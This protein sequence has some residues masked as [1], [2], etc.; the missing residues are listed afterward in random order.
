[1][2]NKV[3]KNRIR[4]F[5]KTVA[6]AIA[7]ALLITAPGLPCYQALALGMALG[8][9]RVN[10]TV[11][12]V[13]PVG[14][15]GHAVTRTPSLKLGVGAIGNDIRLGSSLVGIDGT[16][17]GAVSPTAGVVNKVALIHKP[18]APIKFKA[19]SLIPASRAEVRAR[20]QAPASQNNTAL[21][22]LEIAENGISKAV[23]SGRIDQVARLLGAL[24]GRRTIHRGGL[25]V[26]LKHDSGGNKLEPGDFQPEFEKVTAENLPGKYIVRTDFEGPRPQYFEF[27][28][29]DDKE[30][31]YD[32]V[33]MGS[34]LK[35]QGN[36]QFDEDG[37]FIG[38]HDVS[39]DFPE[40]GEVRIEI[41]LS[42]VSRSSLRNKDEKDRKSVV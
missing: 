14:Q 36:W 27:T 38:V 35:Y 2:E 26:G 31:T 15:G 42:G 33:L 9:V 39:R 20:A 21:S 11:G 29:H 32:V 12:Q 25:P 17:Q 40:I 3:I 1:M 5:R 24:F 13:G 23:S 10:T 34:G 30:Q 18:L 28:I 37:K 19:S 16:F 22:G 6:S 8:S 7:A 41:N 4:I